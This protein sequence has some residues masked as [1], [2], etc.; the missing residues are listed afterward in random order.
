MLAVMKKEK[1]PAPKAPQSAPHVPG[2]QEL[3]DRQ[4]DIVV[5]GATTV[6]R[7]DVGDEVL[8]AFE[9]GDSRQPII[10]GSLWSGKKTPPS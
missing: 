8:I 1:S 3:S 6:T 5:G 10:L 9:Q 4:L 7:P 2:S